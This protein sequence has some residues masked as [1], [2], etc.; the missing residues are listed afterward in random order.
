MPSPTTT[1]G[2]LEIFLRG[3]DPPS[4]NPRVTTPP[5]QLPR[6]S[7]LRAILAS[8]DGGRSARGGASGRKGPREEGRRGTGEVCWNRN[9]WVGPRSVT[10]TGRGKTARERTTTE[11]G[12]GHRGHGEQVSSDRDRRE[13]RG[14][15]KGD[16][17]AASEEWSVGSNEES[18][19]ET[20]EDGMPVGEL[21]GSD[22]TLTALPWGTQE[23]GAG[24]IQGD[25]RAGRSDER[26]APSATTDKAWMR[27]R[28][29]ARQGQEE[30][31]GGRRKT[32]G[33]EPSGVGGNKGGR[34]A[35][36]V[37]PESHG[38]GEGERGCEASGVAENHGGGGGATEWA[39]ESSR[40][41]AP[42]P[43][44]C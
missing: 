3:A 36:G 1:Q 21:E 17:D 8:G 26:K 28:H 9:A 31:D 2:L 33:A 25:A 40:L 29:G 32:V 43:P 13:S 10:E 41:R 7:S 42:A 44:D 19:A 38:V 24:W 30:H 23:R 15:Q 34:E 6:S 5:V 11:A 14:A 4:T 37:D 35:S 12:R 22:D 16:R 18:D 27:G 20:E 39:G